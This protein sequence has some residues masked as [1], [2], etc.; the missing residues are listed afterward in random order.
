MAA[1]GALRYPIVAVNDTYT[2]YLFDNRYG[3]GQSTIDGILRA[4]AILR[5]QGIRGAEIN[6]CPPSFESFDEDCR[7]LGDVE[8]RPYAN[9][10]QGPL[11]LEALSYLP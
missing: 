3:T 9:P 2:K 5:R 1:D 6:L 10:L 11:P 8:A 7:L 4:T